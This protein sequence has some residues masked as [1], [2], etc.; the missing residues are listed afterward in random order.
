MMEQVN[1]TVMYFKN[2]SKCHN[3]LPV[4]WYDNENLIK[5]IYLGLG[6]QNWQ[7]IVNMKANG[8]PFCVGK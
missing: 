8:I 4:Q 6:E 7:N 5:T 2:F 3:L 1:L